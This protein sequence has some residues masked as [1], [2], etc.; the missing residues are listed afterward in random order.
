MN[1]AEIQNGPPP[2]DGPSCSD[3]GRGGSGKAQKGPQGAK[4]PYINIDLAVGTF[5]VGSLST[6]E[7]VDTLLEELKNIHIDILAINETRREEEVSSEWKDG[8]QVLLGEGSEGVGGV[9]FMVGPKA[10]RNII[11]WYTWSSRLAVL[12]MRVSR[13]ATM[14]II[15]AYAPRSIAEEEEVDK[16]YEDLDKILQIESAYTLILGDFNAKVGTGEEGEEYVGRYGSGSR[17]ERGQRLVEY[18]EASHLYIMNTFFMKRVGRRWT[19]SPDEVV[20]EEVDYILT[21]KK[22]LVTDVAVISESV[23]CMQSYH[24]LVRAKVKLNTKLEERMKMKRRHCVRLQQLEEELFQHTVE[25]QNWEMNRNRDY[26]SEYER[27]LLQ[28]INRCKK[29]IT[30]KRPKEPR[31][32][33]SQE[34]LNLLAKRRDMAARGDKGQE[35]KAI[36]KTLR[37]KMTEDYEQY[38][39]TRQ[40][41]AVEERTVGHQRGWHENQPRYSFQRGF[42]ERIGRRTANRWEIEHTVPGRPETATSQSGG[43]GGNYVVRVGVQDGTRLDCICYLLFGH[44]KGSLKVHKTTLFLTLTS[45]IMILQ[46][47]F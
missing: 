43:S 19:W 31:N 20:K 46:N 18:A 14:K 32:R 38:R 39:Q 42:A 34:T 28:K 6:D 30:M 4:R 27:H 16:F 1:R 29:I 15:A 44:C 37:K 10:T 11:S 47:H 8:W 36:C 5:N 9:G 33:L 25:S 12:T 23:V 2:Y 21:D 7:L 41:K 26:D 40:Q 22:Q 35:Y 45:K 24:R 13:D 17:D 3:G